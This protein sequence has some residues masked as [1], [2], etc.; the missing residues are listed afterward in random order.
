MATFDINIVL[1]IATLVTGLI[2]LADAS[3]FAKKRRS[4]TQVKA[5]ANKQGDASETGASVKKKKDSKS[6]PDKADNKAGSKVGNKKVGNKE[7]NITGKPNFIVQYARS[8]FP[9]LFVVLIVRSF[10]VEPFQIPSGSM[11]PSLQVGDFILVSKF[12]YGMRSPVGNYK[13]IETGQ[14]ERGD[15]MVFYYPGDGKTHFIKRVIGLPGDKIS[16]ENKRLYVNGAL[17]EELIV[18][19]PVANPPMQLYQANLPMDTRDYKKHLVQKDYLVYGEDGTWV[20]PAGHYFVMGDNRDNS[21]DSRFW[22]FVPDKLVVGKAFYIWMHWP[23]FLS[24]PGFSRNGT[25]D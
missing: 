2:W 18:T 4:N 16:Y 24:L 10:V 22:G 5:K 9:V 25:I 8:F 17:V 19:D 23:R 7:A 6:N 12:S 3:F 1:V 20:V 21:N 11:L 15:V 13:L 14:P